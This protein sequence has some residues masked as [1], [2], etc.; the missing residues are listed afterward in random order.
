MFKILMGNL[1]NV[2]DQ[3][4]SF[5]GDIETIEIKEMLQIKIKVIMIKIVDAFISTS[6]KVK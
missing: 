1:Y 4:C 2:Q 5:R 3:I 6:I